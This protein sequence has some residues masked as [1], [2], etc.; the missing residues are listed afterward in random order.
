MASGCCVVAARLPYSEDAIAHG[1]TGFL[2]PPGDVPAL[3]SLLASLLADP[4]RARAVGAAAAAA[5]RTRFGVS[6]EA[7][8]LTRVYASLDR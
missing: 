4:V 5:A 8:A 3:R 1:E 2:Y 6:H 7:Q